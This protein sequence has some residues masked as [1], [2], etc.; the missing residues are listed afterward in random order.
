MLVH[1]SHQTIVPFVSH[2]TRNHLLRGRS[3]SPPPPPPFKNKTPLHKQ[4]PA[5]LYE[6]KKYIQFSICFCARCQK[7]KGESVFH[8]A[9]K[10]CVCFKLQPSQQTWVSGVSFPK[11][12]PCPPSPLSFYTHI[13][14][15]PLPPPFGLG[16]PGGRR[17]AHTV[18][19]KQ[20][21]HMK[22]KRVFVKGRLG[23]GVEE[24]CRGSYRGPFPGGSSPRVCFE[25]PASRPPHPTPSS[26]PQPP[27]PAPTSPLLL[28][29]LRGRAR[30]TPVPRADNA[31]WH[32]APMAEFIDIFIAAEAAR[33]EEGGAEK[34]RVSQRGGHKAAVL[35]MNLF[36]YDILTAIK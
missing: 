10:A 31:L 28:P 32:R 29:L 21:G 20:A 15:P 12:V 34:Q 19:E 33:Q 2:R 30:L 17:G 11:Q 23:R 26:L 27:A 8:V 16:S 14:S 3:F 5:A 7:G 18:L 22:R 25:T 4:D 35:F 24:A 13:F 9:S 1:C 6:E 36:F